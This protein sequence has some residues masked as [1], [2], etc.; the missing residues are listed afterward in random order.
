MRAPCIKVPKKEAE[1]IR[2]VL[3]SQ[4]L[5][6]QELKVKRRG[7]YV[8]FPLKRES[9]EYEMFYEDF[10]R[11]DKK[12]GKIGSYDVVGDI[13]IVKAMGERELSKVI[14]MLENRRNIKKIAIDYGVEGEERIRKLKLVKGESFETIH[15]EYGIRLKV[16]ISK[17]YFSPRLA[18]ERWRVV[19]RVRDGEV[20]FDMFA[21][22]G[23]FSILIAK[24]RKVKIFACDINPYAIQYF[25]E[26][27]KLNKVSGIEIFLEDARN[28]AKKIRNVDRVIMNLPHSSFNFLTDALN[29]LKIGGEIHYYEILPRENERER[30]LETFAESNGFKIKIMEKRKV[31]AYSPG[32]DM[33]SFLIKLLHSKDI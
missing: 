3:I 33:F 26:N 17:V 14:K 18:T 32:K 15:R 24:Y 19:E 8:I 31:H 16:D 6:N 21:G 13:A 5:L 22:C 10:E 1:R 7:E 25:K 4:D 23:P 30:D 11:Y 28:L 29:T 12:M 20:I 9:E 27:I 2:R